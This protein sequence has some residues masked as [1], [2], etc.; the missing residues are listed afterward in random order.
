MGTSYGVAKA[1]LNGLTAKLT[2]EE[3]TPTVRINAVCPSFTATFA[4]GEA[5]GAR[6][7]LQHAA[8]VVRAVLQPAAGPSGCFFRHG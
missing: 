6:P 4:G 3:K 1:A 2:H 8:S 5:M 7:V